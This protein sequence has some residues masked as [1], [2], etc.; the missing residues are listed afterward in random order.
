MITSLKITVGRSKFFLILLVSIISITFLQNV[1]ALNINPEEITI[2]EIVYFEKSVCTTGRNPVLFIQEPSGRFVKNP[3]YANISVERLERCGGISNP[4]YIQSISGNVSITDEMESGEYKIFVRMTRQLTDFVY[5]GSLF[6]NYENWKYSFEKEINWNQENFNDSEWSI[7]TMPFGDSRLLPNTNTQ[8]REH[9]KIYL[10]KTIHLEEYTQANLRMFAENKVTC[11]VNGERVGEHRSISALETKACNVNGRYQ[12]YRDGLMMSSTEGYKGILFL[13]ISKYLTPGENIIACVAEVEEEFYSRTTCSYIGGRRRCRTSRYP[14]RQFVDVEFAPL[15][16]NEIFWSYN[17][18]NWERLDSKSSIYWEYQC[19]RR[20]VR[21]RVTA[22]RYV[23][24]K[25][26]SGPWQWNELDLT[27]DD[28]FYSKAE[29]FHWAITTDRRRSYWGLDVFDR[30]TYTRKWVWAD[31]EINMLL[32]LVSITEPY[33]FVNEERI[34]LYNYN[35]DYWNYISEIKLKEGVNLLTCRINPSTFDIFDINKTGFPGQLE[36][37]NVDIK[38]EDNFAKI[39]V[40]L[41]NTSNPE[42]QVGVFLDLTRDNIT[43]TKFAEITSADVSL[44]KREKDYFYD[45]IE[46]IIIPKKYESINATRP[47]RAFDNNWNSFSEVQNRRNSAQFDE[48][49][50]ISHLIENQSLELTEIRFR[51]KARRNTEIYLFNHKIDDFEKVFADSTSSIYT[52]N[53]EIENFSNYI[54]DENTIKVRTKLLHSSGRYYESELILRGLEKKQEYY[55]QIIS[56]SSTTIPIEIEPGTYN[57]TISAVDSITGNQAI[58]FAE[59]EINQTGIIDKNTTYLKGNIGFFPIVEEQKESKSRDLNTPTILLTATIATASASAGAY[60][61]SSKGKSSSLTVKKIDT[62]IANVDKIISNLNNYQAYKTHSNNRT[63]FQKWNEKYETYK[64]NIE[65]REKEKARIEAIRKE[66]IRKEKERK[67]RMKQESGILVNNFIT[68]LTGLSAQE[69]TKAI[70]NFLNVHLNQKKGTLH[71][72]HIW[73]LR[74][75]NQDINEHISKTEAQQ[76]AEAE[77]RARAESQAKQAAQSNQSLFNPIF[78]GQNPLQNQ[79]QITHNQQQENNSWWN[80]FKGAASGLAKFAGIGIQNTVNTYVGIGSSLISGNI[81]GAAQDWYNHSKEGATFLGSV[82]KE[83]WKDIAVAAGVG[84]TAG[85]IIGFTGGLGA[86]IAKVV[87]GAAVSAG[88]FNIGK[89]YSEPLNKLNNAKDKDEIDR[90]YNKLRREMTGDTI[91]IGVGVAGAKFSYGVNKN[92]I[93]PTISGNINGV[94]I[95]KLS[96]K[97]RWNIATNWK[98]WEPGI[99]QLKYADNINEISFV[100]GTSA[101]YWARHFDSGNVRLN[102]AILSKN[103]RVLEVVSSHEAIEN[104]IYSKHGV[105]YFLDELGRPDY[106]KQETIVESINMEKLGESKFKEQFLESIRFEINDLNKKIPQSGGVEIIDISVKQQAKNLAVLKNIDIK[107]YNELNN[108]LMR[109]D[110]YDQILSLSRRYDNV[111]N[112]DWSFLIGE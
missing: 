94:D 83:N 29:Q 14:G 13:G 67:L 91:K 3:D 90:L 112:N 73:H 48:I 82:V 86:P 1:Y 32:R 101:D 20:Y 51:Y 12:V 66:M 80:N 107:T 34:N 46:R 78:F 77:A 6:L 9:N 74:D 17:S 2:G 92:Y 62:S 76:R 110:N 7:G 31:E 47:I 16:Q 33:C 10:R 52:R 109:V 24:T 37:T 53:F 40:H 57:L 71:G 97:E 102:Y 85:A 56:S 87:V 35:T 25:R 72:E 54:S 111:F 68:S 69:Q 104:M 108:I 60:I 43:T 8:W 65:I 42:T 81:K 105:R 88:A 39:K 103:P 59:L 28:V 27:N 58:Y 63:F 106:G 26:W 79:Q 95:S 98:N 89:K 70:D 36:I 75:I 44:E 64:K 23:Q 38:I 84:V 21:D 99:N 100:K 50:D 18:N 61:Y 11:Y 19:V 45:F 49:Y 55:L 93:K 22:L 5:S 41:D 30:T 96:Y 4:R 15:K